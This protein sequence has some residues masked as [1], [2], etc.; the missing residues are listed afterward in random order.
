MKSRVTFLLFTQLILLSEMARAS[1]QSGLR[2]PPSSPEREREHSDR[3][4]ENQATPLNAPEGQWPPTPTRRSSGIGSNISPLNLGGAGQSIVQTR[5]RGRSQ[6]RL[7]LY[8][9]SDTRARRETATPTAFDILQQR[10]TLPTRLRE[11]EDMSPQE[12]IAIVSGRLGVNFATMLSHLGV[13]AA[14]FADGRGV[15][16]LAYI[17]ILCGRYLGNPTER[18]AKMGRFDRKGP[19]P[20]GSSWGDGY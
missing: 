8:G 3:A 9:D 10:P 4:H 16:N 7:L 18:P 6:R 20:G 1:D 11:L 14:S 15:A 17:L 2:S 5:T 13:S 12:T 19:G